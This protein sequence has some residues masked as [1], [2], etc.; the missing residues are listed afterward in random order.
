M[1]CYLRLYSRS[2]LGRKNSKMKRFCKLG[3][4]LGLT[5]IGPIPVQ[6]QS[7]PIAQN[8]VQTDLTRALEA[9]ERKDYKTAFEIW[10]RLAEQDN[11]DAINNLGELYRFGQGVP[12]DTKKSFE[13]YERAANRTD[14]TSAAA[15]NNLGLSYYHGLGTE[16]N[17]AEGIRL[18][19]L[20]ANAGF[21]E[22][23]YH[24]GT[25]YSVGLNPDDKRTALRWFKKGGQQGDASAAFMAGFLL[26]Q[27]N[28]GRADIDEGMIYM[29][30]AAEAG[31]EAATR[32]MAYDAYRDY[33]LGG[34]KEAV[35]KWYARLEAMGDESVA[36]D[37]AQLEK[38]IPGP[39]GY[40]LQE[41]GQQKEAYDSFNESCTRT[42]D[43][44]ACYETA[45]YLANGQYVEKN[46]YGAML[47]FEDVC[48]CAINKTNSPSGPLGCVPFAN[49]VVLQNGKYAGTGRSVAARAILKD[50]CDRDNTRTLDCYN[51]AFLSWDNRFGLKDEGL[52][53]H[54]SAL[55][56]N[57]RQPQQEACRMQRAWNAESNYQ[58]AMAER[59]RARKPSKPG[60]LEGIL[61]ALVVGA[62]E[63]DTSG[64]RTSAATAY[65]EMRRQQDQARHNYVMSTYNKGSANYGRCPTVNSPGC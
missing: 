11:P 29:E 38:I 65:G 48:G 20:A 33:A 37:L 55:A 54:Y 35:L 40:Y 2:V 60:L 62:G 39:R 58:S 3:L 41:N 26:M 34:P 45:L 31:N 47:L 19:T 15:L 7:T 52:S 24:L 59:N 14:N 44:S 1:T 42:K 43:Q 23:S 57:Q 28:Q 13:L 51:V 61:T 32:T 9:Y 64:N 21:A 17:K 16:V 50:S 10:N 56:C 30:L 25:A 36:Y 18:L 49:A 53:R 22:S 46:L 63:I 4:V 27:R 5:T 12:V 6:A 8:A